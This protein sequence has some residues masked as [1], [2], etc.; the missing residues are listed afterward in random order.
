MNPNHDLF[1]LQWAE[2]VPQL[3]HWVETPERDERFPQVQSDEYVTF[4]V[5]LENGSQERWTSW[6]DSAVAYIDT[7]IHYRWFT[8]QSS[9]CSAIA[10]GF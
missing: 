8:Q 7:T 6:R 4:L 10:E 9:Y 5:E 3:I 1:A 2:D